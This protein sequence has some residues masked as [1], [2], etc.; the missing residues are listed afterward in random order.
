M[1][2]N[3]TVRCRCDVG[4]GRDNDGGVREETSC[5]CVLRFALESS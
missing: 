5:E 1:D 2:M 3:D 4:V